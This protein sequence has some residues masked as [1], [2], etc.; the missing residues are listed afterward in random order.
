M[1]KQLFLALIL[2]FAIGMV[3]AGTPRIY[4]QRCSLDTGGEAPVTNG[5]TATSPDYI[6]RATNMATMEVLGTDLGTP[7][8]SIR[9]SRVGNGTTVPYYTA[10]A[11][12]LG[13]FPT[14]WV[15]GNVIHMYVQYIPTLETAEWDMTIPTGSTTINIQDPIQVIP[16]YT[17]QSDT[18]NLYVNT[19]P[20]Q[21][22]DILKDASPTGQVSDHMFTA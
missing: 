14:Q 11:L 3:F 5:A 22:Y 10:V 21:G 6:I 1:K 17:A 20:T 7:A 13:T 9:I 16:P 4:I 18:Y 8:T 19:L 12:Q 2:I 15:A